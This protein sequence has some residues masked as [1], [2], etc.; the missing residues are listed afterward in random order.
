MDGYS[1]VCIASGPSLSQEDVD[2]VRGK[3]KAYVVNDVYKLAPWADALYACDCDWWDVHKPEFSG[4]KYTIS[5]EA[6]N[7]YGLERVE[8]D[9]KQKWG[10]EK[11]ATGGNSGFQAMNLAY[12]HG[13]KKIV[14]LGYDMGRTNGKSHFFGDHPQRLQRSPDYSK[15][16]LAFR[17]AAPYID[18]D[19]INCS[20]E[21]NIDC[22]PR[23]RIQDAL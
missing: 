13:A 4:K 10:K 8:Y 17:E 7:K 9:T 2:Y 3:S 5:E 1:I 23:M 15:W 12:I 22:F 11:I 14:L 16:V 18:V 6:A 19:V 20:R 21:S